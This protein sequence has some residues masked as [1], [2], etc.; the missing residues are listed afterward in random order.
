MIQQ[1]L[2]R[3]LLIFIAIREPPRSV[4]T[5]SRLAPGA[6]SSLYQPQTPACL[7]VISQATRQATAKS[8][9]T[10]GRSSA[11]CLTCAT[12][13]LPCTPRAIAGEHD[14][15]THPLLEDFKQLVK[16]PTSLASAELR[17][18]PPPAKSSPGK[19]RV[20]A[21]MTF[22]SQCQV[23]TAKIVPCY[24]HAQYHR[25]VGGGQTPL[26]CRSCSIAPSTLS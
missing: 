19:R 6:L 25:R 21:R 14:A 7:P 13:G 10:A 9:L 2:C 4:G 24:L 20:C 26:K 16:K 1:P 18:Q 8:S 3:H 22:T 5:R 12:A 17:E 15:I 11:S 23:R